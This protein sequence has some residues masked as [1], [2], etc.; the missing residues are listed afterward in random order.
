MD[1][2]TLPRVSLGFVVYLSK[3]GKMANKLVLSK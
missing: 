3:E 2:R 1:I